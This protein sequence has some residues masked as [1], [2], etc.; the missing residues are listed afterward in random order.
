MMFKILHVG[1]LL[2]AGMRCRHSCRLLVVVMADGGALM[3][4][5]GHGAM[6]GRLRT[7]RASINQKKKSAEIDVL[8]GDVVTA[9]TLAEA[10][11]RRWR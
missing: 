9:A 3:M 11:A 5:T 4:T 1:L 10:S 2:L 7:T 8:A 6:T